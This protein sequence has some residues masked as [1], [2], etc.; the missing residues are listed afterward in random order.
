MLASQFCLAQG[1]LVYQPA[2]MD[3]LQ[4]YVDK[5]TAKKAKDFQGQYQ[6]EIQKML[7]ERRDSFIKSVKD[8]NYIFDSKINGYLK[9]ILAEIYRGNP[10]IDKKDYYFFV[11]KSPVPN[12]A[13]YGN[14]IFT[15]NLGMFNILASDDEVAFAICHEIAHHQLK[16]TDKNLLEHVTKLKSK[17]T[18][19]EFKK[20]AKREYGATRAV[21][22]LLKK[23]KYNFLERS[24]TAEME[25]DSLGFIYLSKTSFNKAAAYSTLKKLGNT[26]TLLFKSDTRLRQHFHFDDYPFKDE[27]L[28][29]DV[30]L[31]DLKEAK[32]DFGF[33]KD[34]VKTHPDIPLRLKQ[35]QRFYPGTDVGESSPKFLE[36]RKVAIDATVISSLDDS[37][38]DMAMYQILSLYE[39]KE[40][41]EKDYAKTIAYLLKRAYDLKLNHSFGK[42]VGGVGTF[43][44]EKYLDEVRLFLNNIELKQT[45]KIGH[46]FC[47]KYKSLLWRDS[48]FAATMAFFERLNAN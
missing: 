39:R 24:R 28:T 27:W 16:H 6:K 14:G 47:Q 18:K 41:D 43:S 2:K 33:D 32:D 26:D 13:C 23:I 12:A 11:D 30:T 25:A 46:R 45:R 48:E 9:G 19:A 1:G 38:I 36:A 20:A 4:Q 15:F 17:E 7:N 3:S 40:V 21:I 31:F 8:S 44:E 42:Y 5:I 35:I 34:S 29:R 10:E 37:R 22:D